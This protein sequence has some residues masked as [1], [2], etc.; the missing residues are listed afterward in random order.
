MIIK[1]YKKI[2]LILITFLTACQLVKSSESVD[3]DTSK[4]AWN[5]FFYDTLRGN[6]VH[7]YIHN[8]VSTLY[9]GEL[10]GDLSDTIVKMKEVIRRP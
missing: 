7:D 6:K 5:K 1:Y 4:D 2:F 8:R 3:I 10:H 9:H